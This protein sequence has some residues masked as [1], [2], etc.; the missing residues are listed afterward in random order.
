MGLGKA[1]HEANWLNITAYLTLPYTMNY[2][3]SADYSALLC[4]FD[5]FHLRFPRTY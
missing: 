1:L 2:H 4:H 5:D 3:F